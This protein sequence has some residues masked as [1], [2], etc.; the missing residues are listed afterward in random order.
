MLGLSDKVPVQ[1]QMTT[2]HLQSLGHMRHLKAI[3]LV[4]TETSFPALPDG[5]PAALFSCTRLE[6]LHIANAGQ[7]CTCNQQY[8]LYLFHRS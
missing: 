7:S 6:R 1:G 8:S 4:F 5:F 2:G 3:K